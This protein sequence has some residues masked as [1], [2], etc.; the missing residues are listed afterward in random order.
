MRKAIFTLA[1]LVMALGNVGLAQFSK[2]EIKN[3]LREQV[4]KQK[5]LVRESY[6]VPQQA[7][8]VMAD[9]SQFRKTYYYDEWDYTCTEDITEFFDDGSWTNKSRYTYEYDFNGNVLEMLYEKWEDDDWSASGRTSYTYN[10]DVLEEMLYQVES[11]GTWVNRLK[12]VYNYNGD[13]W[14]VLT[15]LWEGN[16][17]TVSFLNTY[18]RIGNTIEE[19][20]QYM[21]GGAWQNLALVIETLDFDENVTG[22][23]YQ[24]W[25]E[26]ELE[27]VN[28]DTMSYTF[29]NG[30][31]TETLLQLCDDIGWYDAYLYSYEYD[32]NGNATVGKSFVNDDGNWVPGDGDLEMSYGFNANMEYFYGIEAEMSY[33]DLT[34]VNENAQAV[35]FEVYPVPAEN[36]IQIQAEGFQKAEIFT[37]TGQMLMESEQ[38]T[39]DVS[40]LATGIYMLK[41]YDQTGSSAMQKLVVK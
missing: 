32:G 16:S 1:V 8:Y 35:S 14:T 7:N 6:I 19:L 25:D 10:G 33:V 38:N 15:W 40:S 5:G 12:Y 27:W 3:M 29:E 23:L 26:D 11:D 18:T 20:M 24:Y 2:A 37:L 4:F 41:V 28:V 17:W 39:I 34:S 22:L 21:E 13:Q 9:G 36:E 30:V 31:F